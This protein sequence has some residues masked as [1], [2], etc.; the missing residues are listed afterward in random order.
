MPWQLDGKFLRVN[1]DYTASPSGELWG[2]DLASQPSIKIIASRHDY[3]DQDLGDGIEACLNL[4][5]Y[6]AMRANLNMGGFKVSNLGEATLLTDIPTFG[7]IAGSIDYSDGTKI[8]TLS[9]R[10][11][12]PID[13]TLIDLTGIGAGVTEISSDGS[14]DLTPSTITGTGIIALP[15]IAPGQSY[16]GGIGGL[17]IDDY[18][19]VTQVTIGTPVVGDPDQSLTKDQNFTNAV[20]IG[21][22]KTGASTQEITINGATGGANGRGGVMTRDQVD[23]LESFPLADDIV[24]RNTSQTISASK[25]FNANITMGSN[26]VLDFP[27]GISNRLNLP[28]RVSASQLPTSPGT[29]GDLYVDGGIVKVSP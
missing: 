28:A 22:T 26:S 14:L 5:G 21:I 29:S 25:T 20:K 11:G 8:L 1:P 7:Q 17:V 19:R 27:A 3:H 10:A 12:N 6:N 16:S 9:D 13:T 24:T 2:K 4:D 23:L 18:G 15:T